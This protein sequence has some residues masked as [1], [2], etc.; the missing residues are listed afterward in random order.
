MKC[1]KCGYENYDIA[2]FC[3]YC[4]NP[5]IYENEA[6]K[7]S[8]FKNLFKRKWVKVV[9]IVLAVLIP[10]ITVV[11]VLAATGTFNL[12][13]KLPGRIEFKNFTREDLAFEDNTLFVKK[14]LLI[15]ADKKYNYS[16]I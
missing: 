11:G 10:T 1:N 2:R 16:D 7:K 6:N 14:Q 4:G 12:Y 8:V 15:T 5:L 9:S 3:A 13:K